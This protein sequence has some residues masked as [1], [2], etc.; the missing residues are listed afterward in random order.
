MPPPPTIKDKKEEGWV[1]RSQ[2]AW[3]QQTLSEKLRTEEIV[4]TDVSKDFGSD[5]I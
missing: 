1:A 3:R 4:K 5:M 2:H